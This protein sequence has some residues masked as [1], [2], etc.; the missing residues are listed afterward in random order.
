MSRI[1]T[2]EPNDISTKPFFAV[3]PLIRTR[4]QMLSVQ[5]IPSSL[6]VSVAPFGK[7]ILAN[8]PEE[9][10][11]VDALSSLLVT[12][13]LALCE[14]KVPKTN[15]TEAREAVRIIEF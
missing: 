1:A 5:P 2:M 14:V 4:E 15:R 6:T 11:G 12:K 9:C 13:A 8:S 10:A 3:F 7:V